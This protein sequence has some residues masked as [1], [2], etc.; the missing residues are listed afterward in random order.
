M[1]W[2]DKVEFFS[3][4]GDTMLRDPD[5]NKMDLEL[6]LKMD[7]AR[8]DLGLPCIVTSGFRPLDIQNAVSPWKRSSHPKGKGMDFFFQGIGLL[9]QF[10]HICRYGFKGIGLYPY[11]T[12]PTLH[13]D[14]M[15]RRK[16]YTEIWIVVGKD[17]KLED[18]V[19]APSSRFRAAINLL[20]RKTMEDL[21]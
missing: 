16:S 19:F 21:I 1:D 13:V 4:K 18:Y 3:P 7:R 5:G 20:A 10:F 9:N 15:D 12:P 11:T 2:V 14:V 6:M 8:R 17:G